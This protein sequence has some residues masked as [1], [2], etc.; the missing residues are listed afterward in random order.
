VSEPSAS[1]V[2]LSD[3]AGVVAQ[4][5]PLGPAADLLDPIAD[6]ETNKPKNRARVGS[7]RPSALLYTNGVGAT[8]D[9]PHLAVMPHG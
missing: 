1:D 9:L 5:V 4:P 3:A 8:V 7:V 6:V 2:A